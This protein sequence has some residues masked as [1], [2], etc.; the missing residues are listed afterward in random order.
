MANPTNLVGRAPWANV[1]DAEWNDWKW[2]IANRLRTVEDLKQAIALTTDEEAGVRKSLEHFRM[3]ITPYYASQIE[4][5]NPR[6]PIRMQAIPVGAEAVHSPDDL[7]DPLAEDE[8]APVP[9]LTHR[10][11]DRALFLVTQICSMYCRHCTRRRLVGEKDAHITRDQFAAAYDYIRAHSE[12]RDVIVSGGDPLVMSDRELEEILSTL[13]AIPHVEI[14]RVHTRTPVVLPMRITEDLCRMMRNYHPVYVNTHFNHPRE[15]TAEAR[16]ACSLLADH[17]MPLGNQSVL[18]RW[19]NDCP[20]VMKSL[21]HE[22]MKARVRPYY[23]YQCDLSR[24]I[25]HFRT[26]VSRGIEIIEALR[27]HTTGM[28]VPTF[29]VDAPGGGGKI[30]VMPNYVVSQAPGQIVL[31][32]FEG[33]ITRYRENPD[34]GSGCGLHDACRDPRYAPKEGPVAMMQPDGPMT[35]GP[36]PERKKRKH[37]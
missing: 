7:E 5:G 3:A 10:Y 36:V 21:V 20:H 25:S 13:R 6:C 19:V 35:I 31:R 34:V 4:L 12:I 23:I 26:P 27:G 8:D 24:G 18:L 14:I 37:E 16:R 32:N 15:M 11:P 1:S 33:T 28:A 9:G 17:G 29:V 22:L 30:P 2:Q